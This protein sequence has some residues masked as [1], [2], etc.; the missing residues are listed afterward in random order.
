[1]KPTI[2]QKPHYLLYIHNI[3]IYNKLLNSNPVLTMVQVTWAQLHTHPLFSVLG[4]S[5][6]SLSTSLPKV[7]IPKESQ[8]LL[9]LLSTYRAFLR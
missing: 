4:L 7:V 2:I 9:Y 5:V 1:M 8:I 3:L 6:R